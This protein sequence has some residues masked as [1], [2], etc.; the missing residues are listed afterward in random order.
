[1]GITQSTNNKTTHSQMRNTIGD[2]LAKPINKTYAYNDL[3]NSDTMVDTLNWNN[4]ETPIQKT[5]SKDIQSLL[6]LKSYFSDPLSSVTEYIIQDQR[7]GYVSSNEND[8][9]LS[10]QE[11]EQGFNLDDD[12]EDSNNIIDMLG[13]ANDND[14]MSI[15]TNMSELVKIRKFI[16]QDIQQGGN[17]RSVTGTRPLKG[18]NRKNKLSSDSES[19]KIPEATESDK[20]FYSESS[21]SQ[22]F[23]GYRV[24]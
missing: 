18:G 13:G 22:V 12:D 11:S 6:G 9:D 4:S 1:M 7:A 8:D 19:Y 24:R 10:Q 5:N 14:T 16:E 15:S 2:I 3:F 23:R 20:P 21:E 17:Y